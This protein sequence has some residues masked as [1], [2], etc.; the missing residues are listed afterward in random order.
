MVKGVTAFNW[1]K[2]LDPGKV[3]NGFRETKE[4]MDAILES[5]D[6]KSFSVHLTV[7]SILSD[8]FWQLLAKKLAN[9]PVK[10]DLRTSTGK[11]LTVNRIQVSSPDI[12]INSSILTCL[13]DAAYTGEMK[14]SASLVYD[15]LDVAEK[16]DMEHVQQAC[17]SFIARTVTLSNCI[18]LYKMS[19]EKQHTKLYEAT[20]S[21]M[22]KNFVQFFRQMFLFPTIDLDSFIRVLSCSSLNINE[23]EEVWEAI[24]KWIEFD[25][26]NRSEHL[27]KLLPTMRF[28]RT[29]DGFLQVLLDDPLVKH[30][31]ER[32][33]K[34]LL[35]IGNMV[36]ARQAHVGSRDGHGFAVGPTPV[37]V[38]P[39][40]PTAV[41]VSIGGWKGG[42]T[43]SHIE[44]YDYNT[45]MWLQHPS[46][47][48]CPKKSYHGI[49][50]FEDK[51]WI[52]GGTSGIIIK[53]TVHSWDPVSNLWTQETPL[54]TKR[55]YVSTAVLKGKL[56]AIGGHNGHFRVR[57]IEIYDSLTKEWT[58]GPDM[59]VARSDTTASVMNGK[60]YVMGGLNET[61]I[62]MSAEV[63]DPEKN[64]WT[65]LPG[66]SSRRTS[67]A[68]VSMN[69]FLYAIGGN[70]G[71]RRLATVERYDPQ[72][73]S[74]NSVAN[75]N[76]GRSTFKAVV[77]KG[78]IYVTG[79]YDGQSPISS[80]EKYD[81]ET[82]TWTEVA[83][84]Q[85]SRSGLGLLIIDQLEDLKGFSYQGLIGNHLN[86]NLEVRMPL[87]AIQD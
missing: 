66:M 61:Q 81:P 31:E 13:L 25:R 16:Y 33:G 11:T 77:L 24:K 83:N 75:M 29:K 7:V 3:L 40:I 45:N 74:W 84:M 49:E 78:K 50:W 12:P 56:Y 48:N 59:I 10:E 27:F 55:C 32:F 15:V 62:E 20:L 70:S 73:N 52:L 39:R 82:N 67:F 30:V 14:T 41:I 5:S 80:V 57:T 21:V 79:G 34:I 36:L 63:F 38:C 23:E 69:G 35:T 68:S 17:L 4:W 1:N 6:G 87:L 54:Q 2:N 53:D 76:K 46:C 51:V 43:S 18:I 8:K 86:S 44:V 9:D 72:T 65:L 47:F 22:R 37:S 28:F 19:V 60:I 71:E 85:Y 42:R 64:E 58:P 26:E